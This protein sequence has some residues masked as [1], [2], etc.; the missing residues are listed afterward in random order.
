MK[1]FGAVAGILA[2]VAVLL[3]LFPLFHIVS[4]DRAR[5]ESAETAFDPDKFADSLW[6]ERLGQALEKASDITAVLAAIRESPKHAREEFGRTVGLSRS[7]MFLVKGVGTIAAID[8]SGVHLA[9]AKADDGVD[10]EE[11][12]VV[13]RT[14][15]VFGNTVRDAIDLVR[16]SDFSNSQHYNKISTS[17]NRLVENRVIQP[18]KESAESGRKIEFVGCT[19]IVDEQRDLKPLQVIPLKTVVQ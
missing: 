13:L 4:L 8:D 15:P 19:A 2:V 16:A 3:W 9:I 14:G 12:E 1:K 17:L 10:L 7:Y 5:A 11:A 18:L 6:Q